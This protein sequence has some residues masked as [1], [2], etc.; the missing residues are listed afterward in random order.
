MGDSSVT[1]I[2][3]QIMGTLFVQLHDVLDQIISGTADATNADLR[4]LR[5][6]LDA[7]SRIIIDVVGYF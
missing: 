2:T 3:Y 7:T 1:D 6:V 5:E 4:V